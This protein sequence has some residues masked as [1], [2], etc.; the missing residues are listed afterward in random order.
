MA[1]N[2]NATSS[3]AKYTLYVHQLLCSSPAAT[4]L[5]TFATSTELITIPGHTPA[6]IWSHLPCSTA[7]NKGHMHS[8]HLHTASTC[9]NHADIVLAL[10]KVNQMCPPHEACMVQDMFCFAP[11]ADATLSTMYNNITGAFPIQSFKNM[12]YIFVTYI[13][14]INT[15]IMQPMPSCTDSLFITTFSE[16]FVILRARDYQTALNVMDNKCS[17]AVEK[18]I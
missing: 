3:A 6:L 7:A 4:L 10:A 9:S 5:H 14:N 17:K 12:Q 2:V 13:Y 15:I 18:Q 8:H 11:L 1:A 16:V